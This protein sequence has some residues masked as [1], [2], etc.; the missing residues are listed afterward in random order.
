MKRL[1]TI[2]ILI[3]SLL[4][5]VGCSS[6]TPS[7]AKADNS[8]DLPSGQQQEETAPNGS[9]DKDITETDKDAVPKIE[10]DPE[11]QEKSTEGQ[12]NNNEAANDVQIDSGRFSGRADSNFI[13]IKISG[14]PEEM[15]YRTFMLSEELKENFD[16]LNFQLDEVVK[17]KYT[18]NEHDQGVIFDISRI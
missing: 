7:Q 16:S 17:F 10:G 4:V 11:S 9:G 8:K 5:V 2:F 12:E 6:F 13:E 15:S 18:L 3:I 1:M 14:V